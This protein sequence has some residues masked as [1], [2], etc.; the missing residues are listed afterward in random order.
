MPG[1]DCTV[2]ATVWDS[3]VV[4]QGPGGRRQDTEALLNDDTGTLRAIWFG[5]RYLARTLTPGRRVAISGKAEVFRGHLTF[6]SPAVEPADAGLA[7]IHTGRLV[8]THPLTEGINAR[9]MRGF[10]WEALQ[11]W[12]GGVE[13]TLPPGVAGAELV[14][15]LMPLREAIFQ[16][17]FPDD[18][19]V[20][21]AARDRLAFDELLTLQL[22]V[23][24]RRREAQAEVRGVC[25]SPPDGVIEAFLES[26]P[27]RLTDAQDRCITDISADMKRGAPPM[28]RLL[29]GEVGSGKTVV[30]LAGLLS[31]A[32][33]GFQGALMAPTEVLAEQHFRSTSRLLGHLPRPVEEE[34][35]FS[36]Q[37]EGLDRPV[38]AGLLTGSVRAPVKR[39]LT[40]MAADGTLD[41]VFGTQALIQEGV[42]LP[43]LAL[44]VADEQHRFGVLQR[45][46]LRQ[47]G[48]ENPHT[49]DNV[50]HPP[51]RARCR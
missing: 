39:L 30:A 35:L 20:W 17:H 7:G 49:A 51:S 9:S 50:G 45:T 34:N 27:F 5:Q 12:L 3:R 8:P 44:A 1:Q 29:Q 24:P 41:L 21:Q 13:E 37:L 18:E 38:S 19:E 23:L 16:A 32:A 31:V 4:K 14:E 25:V 43:G 15:G 11:D 10:T 40:G 33:A 22:A 42:T 47:R 48:G 6:E 2:A 46:A 28:N 26:L 36:V